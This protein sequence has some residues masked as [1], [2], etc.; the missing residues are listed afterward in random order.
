METTFRTWNEDFPVKKLIHVDPSQ[1]PFATHEGGNPEEGY[2]VYEPAPGTD[3][4]LDAGRVSTYGIR[5]S[6]DW[7]IIR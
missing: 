7:V 4:I 3:S 2:V 5:V 1:G 6:H